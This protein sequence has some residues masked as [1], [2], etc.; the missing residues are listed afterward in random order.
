[1]VPA[2]KDC[3]ILPP[4]FLPV[5][6]AQMGNG[7]LIKEERGRLVAAR[8]LLHIQFMPPYSS[9]ISWHAARAFGGQISGACIIGLPNPPTKSP[10]LKP[11][12]KPSLASGLIV[13]PTSSP[14]TPKPITSSPSR[15][16]S[17][18]NP[19]ES[20]TAYSPTTASPSSSLTTST[21][22]ESPMTTKVHQQSRLQAQAHPH[23]QH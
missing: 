12:L 5:P 17:I 13:N 10:I 14:S 1:V 16:P 15:S 21:P 8:I 11:S 20:A 4:L 19:T 3:P 9:A 22:T 23:Q 2:S 18:S 6:M 7:M